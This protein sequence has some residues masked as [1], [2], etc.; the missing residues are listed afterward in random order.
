MVES[1]QNRKMVVPN[2]WKYSKVMLGILSLTKSYVIEWKQEHCSWGRFRDRSTICSWLTRRD[3]IPQNTCTPLYV[4]LCQKINYPLTVYQSNVPQFKLRL[5]HKG[6]IGRI[7]SACGQLRFTGGKEAL[8]EAVREF[9]N[10][11]VEGVRENIDRRP[12][13]MGGR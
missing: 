13:N 8:V 2:A 11:L 10:V 9:P 5:W 7:T 3:L 12:L 1:R 4:H 6:V